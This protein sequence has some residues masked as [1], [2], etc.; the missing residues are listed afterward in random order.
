MEDWKIPVP[1]CTRWSPAKGFKLLE[2]W[3]ESAINHDSELELAL[4]CEHESG[5]HPTSHSLYRF[6][7]DQDW[8]ESLKKNWNYFAGA[9]KKAGSL[10]KTVGKAAG[11]AWKE[12]AE[13][14]SLI[15]DAPP[16]APVDLTRRLSAALGSKGTPNPVDIE[17]R[18]LLKSLIDELDKRRT[19]TETQNGGLFHYI[20]DDGRHL[21]LCPDHIRTYKTR[22]N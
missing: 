9:T 8:F 14:A 15:A 1:L 17:A 13:T 7:P 18:D 22:V 21:W 10:A 12:T 11:F 5:W 20:V 3:I 2:T 6:T 4:Y 16:E 19:I